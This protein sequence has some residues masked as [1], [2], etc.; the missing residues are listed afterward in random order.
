MKTIKEIAEELGVSKQ[1]IRN[2]IEKLGLQSKVQTIGNKMFVN[3]KNENI[4][5]SNFS[6]KIYDHRKP[7]TNTRS[8]TFE[9]QFANLNEKSQSENEIFYKEILQ[10]LQNQL[11]VKDK[12]LAEKD[13]QISDLTAALKHHAQSINAR[14]HNQ[15]A[16]TI[17]TQ[18][19]ENKNEN[20]IAKNRKHSFWSKLFNRD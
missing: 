12:Q 6:K 15:F 4:I 7:T 16:D 5:K 3:E 18:M 9:K 10:T 13:K 1:A 11:D 2:K 8:Q 19:I 17:K 14:E 20:Q